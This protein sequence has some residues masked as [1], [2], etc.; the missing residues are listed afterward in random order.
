[1]GIRCLFGVTRPIGETYDI[2]L[3]GGATRNMGKVELYYHG[4]WGVICGSTWD[5]SDGDVV[6]KQ[7]GYSR[8]VQA[9]NGNIFGATEGHQ[10]VW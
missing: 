8:A 7:L 1:M 2:R 6:C 10:L 4:H 5:I 3:I 9:L